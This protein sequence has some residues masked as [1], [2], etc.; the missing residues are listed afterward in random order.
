MMKR[1]PMMPMLV[2][3]LTFCL[4]IPA[5]QAAAKKKPTGK[6]GSK[7]ALN[8][9]AIT[10]SEDTFSVNS[11]LLET[12]N[13]VILIDTQM[14]IM[15]AVKVKEAL[16]KTGK[17]L[18]AIFITHPHPD[19]YNNIGAFLTLNP[20]VPVYATA[21][22][23]K[24]I[25]DGDPE[26][27]RYWGRFYPGSYPTKLVLPTSVV[28]AGDS[29]VIDKL[30]FQIDE[31]DGGESHNEMLIY[32]PNSKDLFV[33][34]LV[35]SGIHANIRERH[36]KVWL[37]NL[38][39]VIGK[40]TDVA[41]LYPGHGS[42]GSLSLLTDQVNY[43]TRFRTLIQSRINLKNQSVPFDALAYQYVLETMA[44]TKGYTN[45][46]LLSLSIEP[47]IDELL[48]EAGYQPE[49]DNE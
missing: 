40:F 31:I 13:S 49:E 30:M 35:Y 25:Q 22:T 26:Q 33:G 23:I 29:L 47:L 4:S 48:Q 16:Q 10:S 20:T 17:P 39:S 27:R 6:K 37:A 5:A 1:F 3:L 19:H 42:Q 11:Y 36:S 41:R 38:Q 34:D 45:K 8:I 21:A 28:K 12:R 7:P 44:D 32:L 46:L 18:A 15:E 2:L 24:A 43:L 14:T 9:R